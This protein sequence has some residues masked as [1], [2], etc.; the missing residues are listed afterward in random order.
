MNDFDN[1]GGSVCVEEEVYG[2]SLYCLLNFIVNE[3]A[4]RS[5]VLKKRR[6]LIKMVAFFKLLKKIHS[7]TINM[8]LY[9]GKRP[10]VFL[11]KWASERLK[12]VRYRVV[13]E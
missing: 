11:W 6:N 3:I 5:K 4:L 10:E 9:L 7:I 12:L 13:V 8:A 2:K 1:W